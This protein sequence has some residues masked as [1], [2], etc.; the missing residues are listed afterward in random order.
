MTHGIQKQEGLEHEDF[1]PVLWAAGET[2]T[3][4]KISKIGLSWMKE[5][6][7]QLLGFLQFLNKGSEVI[8]LFIFMSTTYIINFSIYLFSNFFYHVGLSFASLI[9]MT[10]CN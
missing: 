5:T 2:K 1:Q 6:G 8:F 4:K 10:S 9:W 3:C 7:F